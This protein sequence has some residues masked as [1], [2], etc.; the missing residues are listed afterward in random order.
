MS[1]IS[2]RNSSTSI[3]FWKCWLDVRFAGGADP[4]AT[5]I[6]Y[7]TEDRVEEIK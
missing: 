1:Y 6:T 4:F 2:A 5:L 3:A 7:K